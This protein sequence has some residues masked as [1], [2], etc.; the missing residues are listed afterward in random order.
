MHALNMVYAARLG[1]PGGDLSVADILATL[2]FGVLRVDPKRRATPA[3]I[4]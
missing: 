4:G 1:H 2:Y 3:A